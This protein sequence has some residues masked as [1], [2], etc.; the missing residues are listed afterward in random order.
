MSYVLLLSVVV[1]SCILFI[2]E[3]FFPKKR[4]MTDMELMIAKAEESSGL[5]TNHETNAN[6]NPINT[7]ADVNN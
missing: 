1:G 2:K 4:Q 7:F 5:D 6:L 3:K